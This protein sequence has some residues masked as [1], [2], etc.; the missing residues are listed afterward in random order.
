MGHSNQGIDRPK[1][2]EQPTDKQRAQTVHK[3]S[4]NGSTSHEATRDR[5]QSDASKNSGQSEG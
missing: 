3:T 5:G 4:P 1:G 2:E